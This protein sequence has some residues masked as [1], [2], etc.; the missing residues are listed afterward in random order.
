[1]ATFGEFNFID[2]SKLTGKPANRV[3]NQNGTRSFESVTHKRE[4]KNIRDA[5]EGELGLD[6]SGFTLFYSPSPEKEFDDD[7]HIREVYYPYVE[8]LIKEKLSGVKKVVIFDHTIRNRDVNS[9]RQPVTQ[10]HV[11]QTPKAAFNRV[12]LHLPPEEA[13]ELGKGRFQIINVWRPIHHPA[14]DWPLAVIDWRTTKQDDFIATDLLYPLTRKPQGILYPLQ[15]ETNG[16]NGD[17]PK[18]N[19]DKEEFA[20]RGETYNVQYNPTH[21]FWYTKDMTPDEVLFIKCADSRGGDTI[22][23]CT[24]HTAFQDPQTPKDAPGRRSIEVRTLVFYE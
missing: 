5:K 7:E 6:I 1:M 17:A 18:T 14:S 13:E 12:K 24:P 15:S 2:T 3:D 8:N 21:Q 20:Y 9:A 11:D 4:V 16:T 23:K 10:V 19:G 22:A